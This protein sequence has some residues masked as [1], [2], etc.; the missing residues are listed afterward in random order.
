[1]IGKQ[2]FFDPTGKRALV[3]RWLAW[4]LGTLSALVMIIFVA[5]LMIVHHPANAGLDSPQVSIRCAW[6]PTCSAAH[7]LTITSAAD[8]ELVKTATMLAAELRE[9][10]RELRTP[11]PQTDAPNRRPVPIALDGQD[12]R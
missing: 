10:E 5:I 8:P 6:A 4:A 3:L 11:H 9:K 1:M 12:A 7:A 2:I